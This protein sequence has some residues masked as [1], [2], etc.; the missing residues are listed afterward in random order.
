M[1]INLSFLNSTNGM[2]WYAVDKIKTIDHSKFTILCSKNVYAKLRQ[3]IPEAKIKTFSKLNS[4]LYIIY[5]FIISNGPFKLVTFTSHPI[6]F[7]SNQTIAFYDIYPFVGKLGLVKKVLFKIATK[8]SKCRVGIINR[9]LSVPFLTKCGV[10]SAKIFFD[11]AFPTVKMSEAQGRAT[12]PHAP[13]KVGLVGTDSTKKNYDE[14]FNT[15]IN[16]G[17]QKDIEFIIF[18]TD[19]D[20]YRRLCK[21]YTDINIRLIS[22]DNVEIL[23]Y[24]ENIDYL[25]SAAR[26]E[27]YGRPMGL[28]AAVG[29]PML[30][31]KSDVFMEF[32]GDI[33]TFFDDVAD[34]FG[35]IVNNKPATYVRPTAGESFRSVESPFFTH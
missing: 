27:G 34:I 30:L 8:T 24:F 29:V 31:L 32:F 9:S 21:D 17:Y 2:F 25:V 5:I 23:E 11:S 16:L 6:P 28:A 19:N 18:G 20:Y 22:S 26:D 4:I 10:S 14:L 7:L 13:L 15:I 3:Q 12:K 35:F 1:I 33:A